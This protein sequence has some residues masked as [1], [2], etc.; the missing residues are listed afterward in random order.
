MDIT[1]MD[2]EMEKFDEQNVQLMLQ[3]LG[4]N[5]DNYFIAMTKPSLL[6]R[7]LIGNI[8]DFS[9]RYCII[10]FS[11]TELNLIMLSRINSKKVTEILKIDHAEISRMKM[12]DI[13]ISYMLNITESQSTIKFQVLKKVAKF[14]NLKSSIELFKKMYNL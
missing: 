9:N 3:N 5:M 11:E 6:N 2:Y 4:F 10:V 1:K 8:V 12:S 7:A 13:L 14:N